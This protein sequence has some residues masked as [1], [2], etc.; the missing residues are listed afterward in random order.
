M[1]TIRHLF[2]VATAAINKADCSC[3]NIWASLV[4]E[5]FKSNDIPNISYTP[6]SS[7]IFLEWRG[8][9]LDADSIIN[10]MESEGKITPDSFS[11][12]RN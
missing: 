8:S 12:Y 9:E 2:E 11:I 5:G 6:G 3:Q 1:A 10:I 7:E 4:F